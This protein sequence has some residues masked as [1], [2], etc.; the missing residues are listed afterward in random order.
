MSFDFQN[1]PDRACTNSLKWTQYPADVLPLWVADM[2]FPAPPPILAALRGQL[3]HAILGYEFARKPLLE[4]VARRMAT[5][6]GWEVDPAAV[7]ATPGIIAAFTAAAWATCQQGQGILTQPPVYPPFLGVA[8]N[9]GLV[10]QFAPL[11]LEAAGS[12]VSYRFD[13]PAFRAAMHRDGVRTGMFLLCNPHNP[14]GQTYSRDALR[15]MAEA[16]LENEVCLVSDEIHSELLLGGAQHIPVATL[17]KEIERRSITLVAPSKTYNVPG[18]FCGF[19]IIPDPVLRKRFV[20]ASER[21]IHHVSSLSLTAAQAAYSGACDPWL[22]ALRAHL[23][24]NRDRVVSELQ[25]RCPQ[26]K[27]TVPQATYLAWIHCRD[28]DLNGRTA[29]DHFLE[30]AR[31]AFTR[32]EDFGPGGEGFVRLNFGTSRAILEQALDRVAA[33]LPARP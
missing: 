24:A 33:A 27:T 8:A 1:V 3:D 32:G 21:L 14:T 25:A 4:T 17:S 9:V 15:A 2:D 26:L 29:Y 5:L 28:L 22:Q 12:T 7:V 10:N 13:V 30:R 19:A 18:L 23:T 6:Y 16:C 20:E 11:V 31:V